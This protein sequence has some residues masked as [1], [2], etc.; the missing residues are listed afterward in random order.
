MHKP[1]NRRYHNLDDTQSQ[2]YMTWD[3]SDGD[4]I[5]VN[6]LLTYGEVTDGKEELTAQAQQVCDSYEEN[7]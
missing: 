6:N 3:L 7:L 2:S 1:T 4:K 5:V